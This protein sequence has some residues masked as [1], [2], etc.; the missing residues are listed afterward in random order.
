[1]EP[2]QVRCSD[3]SGKFMYI[4]ILAKSSKLPTHQLLSI[5]G[6]FVPVLNVCEEV[7]FAIHLPILALPDLIKSYLYT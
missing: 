7:I 1:M 5:C 2:A 6:C 3:P 4:K